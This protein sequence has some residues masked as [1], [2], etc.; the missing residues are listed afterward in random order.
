MFAI[1]MTQ[2]YPYAAVD[3]MDKFGVM[4]YQAIVD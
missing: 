3:L 4:V 1:V 2:L